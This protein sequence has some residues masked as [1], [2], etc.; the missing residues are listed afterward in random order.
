MSSN[1]LNGL[2]ILTDAM[3]WLAI[4]D[5]VRTLLARQ[6]YKVNRLNNSYSISVRNF[7]ASK[8]AFSRIAD[9]SSSLCS[10]GGDMR[11][12]TKSPTERK[13]AV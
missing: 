11:V 3:N 4:L 10:V 1:I 6:C 12:A 5:E 8:P 2:R 13:Y 7:A 9:S